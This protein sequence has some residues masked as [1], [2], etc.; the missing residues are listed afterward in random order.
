MYLLIICS[1]YPGV[2]WQRKKSASPPPASKAPPK[3]PSKA[4]SLVSSILGR[5]KRK[6]DDDDFI[7]DLDIEEESEN[8]WNDLD[9]VVPSDSI[10]QIG[11][12]P[13]RKH[14]SHRSKKHD[15]DGESSASRRS[16]KHNDDGES[17]TSR[18]SSRKHHDDDTSSRVSR[19]SRSHR[20][21]H[22]SS[23]DDE[24]S[25]KHKSHRSRSKPSI[26][27]EPSDA[28]TVRPGKSSSKAERKDSLTQ[29]QYDNLF[30][31]VQYGNGSVPIRAITGSMVSAARKNPNRGMIKHSVA[32]KMRD[33]E[34]SEAGRGNSRED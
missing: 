5:N 16:K 25:S 3:V 9:T 12:A 23:A 10:S 19:S 2:S 28:S 18:R 30:D 14:R 33:F 32:Q 26:V 31:Q 11:S 7:D 1:T 6:D 13:R 29:G 21:H 4:A 34:G 27:S 24:D 22:S 17:S 20:T 15:D 8:E